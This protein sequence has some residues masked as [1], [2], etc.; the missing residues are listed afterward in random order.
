MSIIEVK[1]VS[2]TYDKTKFAVKNVSF[3]VK[4]G[5]YVAIIGHNGSGKS[6]LAKLFNAL[7]VPTNGEII[8]D[9]I[10]TSQK[11]K[12]FEIRKKVGVVFQNPDNGIVASI[13]EDDIAFGPENI[14]VKREEIGERIDFALKTVGMEKFRYSSPDRLSGG[15]KQRIAIAGVL[16]LKPKVIVLDEST[17]MLD[18]KGRQEIL[19][20]VKKLNKEQG[21][22][23]I[24]ITH[25]MDEV[26]NADKVY[27]LDEGEIALQ[28]TPREI[29]KEGA[30]IK[31]IGLELPLASFIAEK[32]RQA[33][34]PVK[35]GILDKEELKGAICELK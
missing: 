18:P 35:D 10:S 28:G 2:Y 15:Q 24:A 31:S 8:V 9:G 1:N 25:Y 3:D 30:K 4:E 29:F 6:T 16:A 5:E 13:V 7:F 20:V 33:G 34:V 26:L 32:L 14:G 11:D 12:L 21:V 27:V 23:V 22:T 19:N 17:A